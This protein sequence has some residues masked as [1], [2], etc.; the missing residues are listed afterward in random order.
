MGYENF[1][2]LESVGGGEEC[3]QMK[4]KLCLLLPWIILGL[5]TEPIYFS[6]TWVHFH[7]T[8]RLYISGDKTLENHICSNLWTKMGTTS[9][10]LLALCN[11]N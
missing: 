9:P 6:E 1:Y 3:S 5:E 2:L 10:S 8:A 7:P 11:L 4:A